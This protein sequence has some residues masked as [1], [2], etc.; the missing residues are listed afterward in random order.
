MAIDLDKVTYVDGTTVVYAN[1]L[2]QIQQAILDLEDNKVEAETGKG[3]STND[4][5]T[6]EKQKLSVVNNVANLEYVV[7]TE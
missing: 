6:A 7:V 1:N 4:Y 3:L 2:N 5:T